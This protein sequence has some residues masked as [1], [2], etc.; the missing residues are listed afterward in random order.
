M[1]P[2]STWWKNITD[3]FLFFAGVIMSVVGLITIFVLDLNG[4]GALM[5]IGGFVIIAIQLKRRAE[6]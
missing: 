5:T 6:E 4:I 3:D 1:T 2:V